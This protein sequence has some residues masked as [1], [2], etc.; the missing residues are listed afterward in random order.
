MNKTIKVLLI[1]LVFGL[2]V[3]TGV[4]L[5][6]FHKPHRN[7]AN[8]KPAFT[9]TSTD[10]LKQFSENEDSCNKIYGNKTIEVSGKIVDITK[11]EKLVLS[12]ILNNSST[13]VNCYFDSLYSSENAPVINNFEIGN[14][15]KLKGKCDG[16][17]D[18]MG[19]VLNS[20]VLVDKE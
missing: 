11:K 12:V 18:I 10:L 3:G 17:D 4:Y 9:L 6:V 2:L 20:C 16:Y 19:V 1:L 14:E 13:G 15:I 8:E 7:I 5:Y